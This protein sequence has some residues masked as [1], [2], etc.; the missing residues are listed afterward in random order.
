MMTALILG[1][2]CNCFAHGVWPGIQSSF[3]GFDYFDFQFEGL[4]CKVLVT[5]A[6]LTVSFGFGGR[7]FKD[8]SRSLIP[9]CCSVGIS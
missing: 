9:L 1:M 7:V 3:I 4:G 5:K 2:A 6:L 8:I